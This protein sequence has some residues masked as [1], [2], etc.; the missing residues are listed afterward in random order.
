MPEN[1]AMGSLL[2]QKRDEILRIAADH[3]ARDVRVFGSLARGE[4]TE[5]SD[6]DLLVRLEPGVSLLTHAR[7]TRH[8]EDLLGCKVDVVSERGL[9]D[10]VRQRVLSEAVPL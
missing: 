5:T 9:R 8:L 7:L 2:T 4:L 3:G 1:L 6:I 10:R